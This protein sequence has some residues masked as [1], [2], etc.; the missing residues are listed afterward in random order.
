MGDVEETEF[1]TMRAL[2][3]LDTAQMASS[4]A[5]ESAHA[6]DSGCGHDVRVSFIYNRLHIFR[7]TLSNRITNA[8]H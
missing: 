7:S 8:Q 2:D 4:A 3:A 1:V 5:L 6:C